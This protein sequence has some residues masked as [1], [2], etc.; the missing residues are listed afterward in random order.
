[1]ESPDGVKEKDW[2]MDEKKMETA[3]ALDKNMF[4]ENT[5][6]NVTK[7]QT[8]FLPP[9]AFQTSRTACEGD[10][11]S[12]GSGQSEEPKPS[13]LEWK[14]MD[15]DDRQMM[16]ESI[17][18]FHSAENSDV[19][20]TKSFTEGNVVAP[21]EPKQKEDKDDF[22]E[23]DVRH[24]N[25][26]RTKTSKRHV[27]ERLHEIVCCTACGQQVNHYEDSVYRH[28]AL[29]VLICKSCYI[30]TNDDISHDS[31]RPHKHCRSGVKRALP[32]LRFSSVGSEVFLGIC[33]FS[34]FLSCYDLRRG[35]ITVFL[36]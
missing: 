1:M 23:P 24:K 35:E 15:C 9:P 12:L 20:V 34:A 30:Y 29:N 17:S 22:Q 4:P 36:V 2:E 6:Y 26:M 5:F 7:V 13:C 31:T 3:Q 14:H 8:Q 25:R 18:A 16:H 28:P 11:L 10:I 21:S 27:E 32:Q 19:L 33:I